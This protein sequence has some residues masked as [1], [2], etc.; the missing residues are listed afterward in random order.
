MNTT[1]RPT[2]GAILAHVRLLRLTDNLL[3]AADELR[4]ARDDLQSMLDPSP[5]SSGNGPAKEAQHDH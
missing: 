2:T 5:A 4:E 1:T 3:D